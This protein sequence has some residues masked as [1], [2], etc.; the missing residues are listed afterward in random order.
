MERTKSSSASSSNSKPRFFASARTISPAF[1]SQPLRFRSGSSKNLNVRQFRQRL[2]KRPPLVRI[3]RANEKCDVVRQSAR[4]GSRRAASSGSRTLADF[5]FT[6]SERKFALLSQTSLPPPKNGSV[7]SAAMVERIAVAAPSTLSAAPS[8]IS[9]SK[10][11][12][13]GRGEFLASSAASRFTLRFVGT[14]DRANV[15]SRRF[16]FGF[17]HRS[18][19]HRKLRADSAS[20][21][22]ASCRSE[23]RIERSSSMSKS[24]TIL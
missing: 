18:L 15:G 7:C 13:L 2:V 5:P 14:D 6:S 4:S 23:D 17:R 1:S 3:D 10:L 12:R 22:V 24:G 9:R 16:G 11:A 21:T 19:F 20:D 8:M